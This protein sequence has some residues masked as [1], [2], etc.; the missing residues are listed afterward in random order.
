MLARSAEPAN[1]FTRGDAGRL[2][3]ASVLLVVAMSFILGLD[4]LPAQTLLEEGRPAP[5]NVE[6]PRT[7]SY[8]SDVLTDREREAARAAV[9][10]Q[11]DYTIPRG[12]AVAA[13][14]LR[15]LDDLVSPI[16]ASFAEGISDE[17]RA[18][19]LEGVLPGALGED[20]RATLLALDAERWDAVRSESERVLDTVERS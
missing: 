13:Q 15:E 3:V 10:F 8:V 1:T 4:F 19:I 7:E 9:Q 12:A 16:D 14:Q 20:E 18:A 5:A 17:D 11:Y 2:A 6:A